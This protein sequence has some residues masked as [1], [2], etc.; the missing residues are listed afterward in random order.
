M[1]WKNS[2]LAEEKNCKLSRFAELDR[3]LEN[4]NLQIY[5]RDGYRRFRSIL[6]YLILILPSLSN[7]HNTWII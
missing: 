7:I 2:V 4:K 6:A 5:N 1:I 3:H